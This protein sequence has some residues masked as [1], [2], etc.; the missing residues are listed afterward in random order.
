MCLLL[1]LSIIGSQEKIADQL[2]QG[3]FIG[4]T[5]IRGTVCN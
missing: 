3:A 5:V 4:E 2:K 1:R